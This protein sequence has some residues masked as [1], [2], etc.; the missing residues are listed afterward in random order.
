[1]NPILDLLRGPALG[2]VLM[3]LLLA[4]ALLVAAFAALVAQMSL[5][6]RLR[7]RS[8][9]E[10]KAHPPAEARAST[11]REPRPGAVYGGQGFPSSVGTEPDANE[12]IDAEWW[13]EVP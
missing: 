7:P 11:V 4:G 9:A 10:R 3:V 2:M 1:M 8:A 13:Q 6:L 12:V 5:L